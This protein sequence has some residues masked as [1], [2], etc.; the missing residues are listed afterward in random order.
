[1]F[2]TGGLFMQHYASRS[3]KREDRYTSLKEKGVNHTPD[4]LYKSEIKKL[5]KNGYT[6]TPISVHPVRK[7]LWFCEVIFPQQDKPKT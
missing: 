3:E 6:V 1:M 2:F 7:S 5:E 4:Y